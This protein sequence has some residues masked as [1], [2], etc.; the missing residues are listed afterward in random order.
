MLMKSLEEEFKGVAI[1]KEEYEK[2]KNANLAKLK[3]IEGK[4]KEAE[5]GKV[6]GAIKEGKP[7]G[8]PKKIERG[9]PPEEKGKEEMLLKDLEETFKKGFISKEAYEKT[10]KMILRKG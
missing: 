3:E 2:M 1:S 9:I 8:K 10:K 5:K 4:I 6:L 7:E